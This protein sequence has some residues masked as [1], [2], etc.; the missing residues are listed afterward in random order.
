LKLKKKK[1][2]KKKDFNLENPSTIKLIH[3]K[4]NEHLKTTTTT[5]KQNFKKNT[6]HTLNGGN[7]H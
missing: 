2:K 6:K 1:K 5:T 7:V 3:L 4:T